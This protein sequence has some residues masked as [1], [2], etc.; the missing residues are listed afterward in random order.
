MNRHRFLNQSQPQTLVNGT[1][2]CYFQAFFA[3][4]DGGGYVVFVLLGLGLALG[5]FGIANDKKWGYGV[6]VVASILNVGIWIS[7]AGADV[8][9]FPTIISFAFAV[10]LVVLLTHPMSREYQRIWFE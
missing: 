4:I 8:L 3:F 10:V 7:L 1:L 2:L 9:G 5:G 6:A